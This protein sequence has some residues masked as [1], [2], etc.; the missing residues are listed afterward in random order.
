MIDHFELSFCNLQDKACGSSGLPTV[1][2][3]SG[4]ATVLLL[5]GPIVDPLARKTRA[6][7][8]QIQRSLNGLN[9]RE[10]NAAMAVAAKLELDKDRFRLMEG[11]EFQAVLPRLLPSLLRS[12]A[13][14][15]D[16]SDE[17]GTSMRWTSDNLLEEEGT[18]LMWPFEDLGSE[19]GEIVFF[20]LVSSNRDNTELQG[21]V[22]VGCLTHRCFQRLTL[23]MQSTG[24]GD[25]TFIKSGQDRM[26][27]W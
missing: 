8:D 12:Q 22:L 11:A 14:V 5:R 27:R 3:D 1:G 21:L 17:A 13:E 26:S 19:A 24:M 6:D 9:V 23:A 15:A 2:W 25:K 18:P 7:S 16:A 10:H 20:S 4:N